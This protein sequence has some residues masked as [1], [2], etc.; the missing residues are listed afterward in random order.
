MNDESLEMRDCQLRLFDCILVS[1]FLI[2]ADYNIK[3][4]P[5][6]TYDGYSP[7]FLYLCFSY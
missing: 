7:D 4:N 6:S 5:V 3:E 1:I 2:L